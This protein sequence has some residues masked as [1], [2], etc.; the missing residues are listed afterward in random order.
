MGCPSAP[1]VIIDTPGTDGLIV[2]LTDNAGTIETQVVTVYETVT[3]LIYQASPEDK[4][5]V[6]REFGAALLSITKERATI[7]ELAR[8]HALEIGKIAEKY[9]TEIA[10]LA[11]FE[12]LYEKVKGQRNTLVFVCVSLL[13][14]IG[15]GIILKLK[16]W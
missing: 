15:G 6:E 1:P 16:G 8:V 5:K 7:K 12:P 11:P 9:G 13:L 2:D 3:K 14:V 10:R 4:A